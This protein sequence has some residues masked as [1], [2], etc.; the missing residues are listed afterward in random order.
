[1]TRDGGFI[2]VSSEVNSSSSTYALRAYPNPGY[3]NSNNASCQVFRYNSEYNSSDSDIQ[4][5]SSNLY[6]SPNWVSVGSPVYL[7]SD[8]VTTIYNA[9][10]NL[11][12]SNTVPSNYVRQAQIYKICGSGTDCSMGDIKSDDELILVT[13]C[14]NQSG[15]YFIYKY[16]LN[17]NKWDIQYGTGKETSGGLSF[18]HRIMFIENGNLLIVGGNNS[19]NLVIQI[20]IYDRLNWTPLFSNW[21]N[22]LTSFETYTNNYPKVIVKAVN[23]V[24]YILV[25]IN[26]RIEIR[27]YD[28]T[29]QTT[30]YIGNLRHPSVSTDN[31]YYDPSV[32]TTYTANFGQT[33]TANIDCT[34]IFIASSDPSSY[35][36]AHVFVYKR[37]GTVFTIHSIIPEDPSYAIANYSTGTLIT[38]RFEC[39]DVGTIL[40]ISTG[41][42]TLVYHYISPS[43]IS[44][45]SMYANTTSASPDGWYKIATPITKTATNG[46]G[47]ILMNSVGNIVLSP[48]Y[49]GGVNKPEMY[50][51]D[52]AGGTAI[53]ETTATS[54]TT[55]VQ[56]YVNF[57]NNT[58]DTVFTGDVSYNSNLYVEGNMRIKGDLTVVGSESNE[59]IMLTTINNYEVLVTQD[60]SLNG[61][62]NVSGDVSMNGRVDIVGTLNMNSPIINTTNNLTLGVSGD[63]IQIPGN[64]NVTGTVSKASGTFKIDHPLPEK[65]DT[66]YLIHS[67]IEGPRMDNIYRGH[68][69][70]EN[71]LAEINLDTQFNMTEGTFVALNRDISVFTTNEDDWDNVRG[72]VIGNILKIECQNTES[73]ALISYLVI[74]ERQDK[75]AKETYITDIDGRLITEPFK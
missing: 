33:I 8:D 57:T 34:R 75:H 23:D 39:N 7:S 28:S 42:G 18:V 41:T 72:K 3:G 20:M 62:M 40:G 46:N 58:I 49:G 21:Y 68:I 55:I 74:G 35:L 26:G 6:H 56:P 73:T 37:V 17:S 70:L 48:A 27:T 5:P 32:D 53:F 4:D 16:N 13:T 29:T 19:N 22:P 65:Q 59:N 52:T 69:H 36:K 50:Q 2:V 14:Q 64:L 43:M 45:L 24:Y 61:S 54:T 38:Q 25:A 12:F 30:T 63:T 67:F 11:L 15:A 51:I 9:S 44:D 1:M 31:L 60:I 47:P 10:S 66:H 71:G